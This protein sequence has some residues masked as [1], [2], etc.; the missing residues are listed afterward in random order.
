MRWTT[1]SAMTSA[2]ALVLV[3]GFGF[4]D[5][6]EARGGKERASF[7]E[8]DTDGN[9]AITQAELQARAQMR[10]NTVDAD[11]DGLVTAE[12]MSAQARDGVSRRV[13][14]MISRR[15]ANDDG[16]LS[17]DEMIGDSAGK[18]FARMDADGDGSI[19]EEEFAAAQTK[20]GARFGA[21]KN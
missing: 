10:F 15:D 18:G 9:G 16:A 12:E 21:G 20:R 13:E 17:F 8:I 11:G 6:A 4:A 7:S 2:V 14:R 19:S 5:P 3:T 1:T